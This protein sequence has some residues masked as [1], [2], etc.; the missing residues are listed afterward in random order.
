MPISAVGNSPFLT[1]FRA[2][3]DEHGFTLIEL[4]IVVTIIGLA[5]A[6]VVLALP[7]PRGRLTDE[8]ERF[9]ART[10]AA[11]DLAIVGAQPISVWVSAGGYGFDERRDG[12]WVA[13][14]ERPLRVTQ[15]SKGTSAQPSGENSRDR[16]LFDPTGIADR[17]LDVTLERSDQT[18]VVHV[19]TDGKV[20]IGG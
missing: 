12:A 17:P 9:A 2:S 18:I 16:V 11:H 5:S 6:A 7:D 10:R 14:A 4:M 19:G 3:I 13:M 15:W 8:A 1:R 20:R